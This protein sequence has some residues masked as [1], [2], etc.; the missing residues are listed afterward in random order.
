MRSVFPYNIINHTKLQI[1]LYDF[2]CFFL[3]L[4]KTEFIDIINFLLLLIFSCIVLL[5]SLIS[6]RLKYE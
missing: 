3:L 5:N 2:K 4:I 6:R 1:T